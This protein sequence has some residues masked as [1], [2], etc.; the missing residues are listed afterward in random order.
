MS[1]EICLALKM[2]GQ[3]QVSDT[4][5]PFA[6]GKSTIRYDMIRSLERLIR[7]KDHQQ[8]FESVSSHWQY[9]KEEL[10]NDD[11][12]ISTSATDAPNEQ[13]KYVGG[14]K[15]KDFRVLGYPPCTMTTDED[16]VEESSNGCDGQGTRA[17]TRSAAAWRPNSLT[18]KK[19]KPKETKK[20]RRRITLLTM[21]MTRLVAATSASIAALKA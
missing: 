11:A 2:L 10:A 16:P 8:V 17:R 18:S 4:S 1:S 9:S 14:C 19:R 13:N 12:S 21:T 5:A 7:L 3:Q 6:I 20:K 15:S